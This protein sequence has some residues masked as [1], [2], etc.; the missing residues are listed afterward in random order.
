MNLIAC[1]CVLHI[2]FLPRISSIL[3]STNFEVSKRETSMKNKAF[4]AI[5]DFR[6]ATAW[7][8]GLQW[9]PLSYDSE[10]ASLFEIEFPYFVGTLILWCYILSPT[11]WFSYVWSCQISKMLS[12]NNFSSLSVSTKI[13]EKVFLWQ[14]NNKETS[15]DNGNSSW[16]KRWVQV[17]SHRFLWL[18]FFS[19][20]LYTKS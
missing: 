12:R 17:L 13:R 9:A 15:S 20:L 6:I 4:V 19:I 10:L 16:H 3:I 7:D 5:I 18:F 2:H 1:S 8:N 11:S 14:E